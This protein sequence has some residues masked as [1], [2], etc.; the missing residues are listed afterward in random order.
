MAP[1]AFLPTT[2]TE[3]EAV[4]FL[5]RSCSV[6]KSSMICS[7]V[8]VFIAAMRLFTTK[9]VNQLTFKWSLP[10]NRAHS[11]F[12][13]LLP[14]DAPVLRNATFLYQVLYEGTRLPE[15]SSFHHVILPAS[16]SDRVTKPCLMRISSPRMV[17]SASKQRSFSCP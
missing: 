5:Y 12:R 9:G 8:I 2:K 13:S 1:Q 17:R 4:V 15:I 6:G 10:S 11:R 7:A 3:K 16:T 14:G